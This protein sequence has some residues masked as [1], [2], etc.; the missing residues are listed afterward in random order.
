ME[1]ETTK[2]EVP[3]EV[4]HDQKI[5]PTMWKWYF[6]WHPRILLTVPIFIFF[7]Y[8]GLWF[9]LDEIG[10]V[11][12][13]FQSKPVTWGAVFLIIFLGSFLLILIFAPIYI[14]FLSIGW[15]YEIMIGNHGAWKKFLYTIG[16]IL[17][18]LIGTSLIRLFTAWILGIL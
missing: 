8:S 17:L 13:F 15:L 3:T 2:I 10:D 5:P 4:H 16:I 18:V 6:G 1:N 14:C 11:I 12:Y 9:I 7:V